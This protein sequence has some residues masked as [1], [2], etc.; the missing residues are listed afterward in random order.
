MDAVHYEKKDHVA[1]ISL[2]NPEKLNA[3]SRKM[4]REF[5]KIWV[6]FR[7]DK[8]LWVG[9]LKGEGKSFCAGADVE[10]MEREAWV[11]QQS[12]LFGDDR[13]RP[14]NYRVW[15]PII[16]AAQS[17]VYGMGLVL[18][19]ESDIRIVADDIKMGI[20]EGRVNVPFLFAPFIFDYMPRALAAEL[21]HTGKTI[22][23]E[24]AYNWGL[25]NRVVPT[26]RLLMS[27][28]QMAKD[29]CSNGPLANWAAK[30]MYCRCRDMDFQSALSFMEHITAPVMNSIDSIEAKK[31]FIEK[32]KPVWKVQ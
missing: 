19:L 25:V 5:G 12:L 8:E 17:H 9:I 7:D 29:V 11:F 6:D 10:E 21:I 23:A 3:I 15:K 13:A 20:P 26:D 18:F 24:K 32:R 30:E 22:D 2:N 16:V 4:T 27:A 31:A 28:E 14:S 1:Y